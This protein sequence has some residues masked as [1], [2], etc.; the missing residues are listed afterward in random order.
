MRASGSAAVSRPCHCS[1]STRDGTTHEH[2]A[3]P[4]QRVGGGGDRDV[5]L[6]RTGDRFDDTAPAAAQPADERVE[7]PPVELARTR[8]PDS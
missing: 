1:M 6:A 5:G 8:N 3:A 2:E 4:A 7:L